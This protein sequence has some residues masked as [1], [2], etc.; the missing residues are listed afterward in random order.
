MRSVLPSFSTSTNTPSL[1]AAA[2]G[3]VRAG[4]DV[5][6]LL[7]EDAIGLL[8][9]VVVHARK[10]RRQQL[11]DGDLGAEPVPDGAELESDHAAADDDQVLRDL[12]DDEGADVREDALFVELEEGELDRYGAGGNDDV[13]AW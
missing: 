6:A 10:D 8:D 4:A 11:D 13:F 9:D 12:G 2:V 7:A 1:G 3:D 5:E